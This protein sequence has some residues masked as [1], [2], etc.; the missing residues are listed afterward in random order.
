[1]HSLIRVRPWPFAICCWVLLLFSMYVPPTVFP[2]Y[3]SDATEG[4]AGLVAFYFY[5]SW[6]VFWSGLSATKTGRHVFA[7]AMLLIAAALVFAVC[8]GPI[9]QSN[10]PWWAYPWGILTG[11]A[12]FT[13]QVVA[14]STLRKAELARGTRIPAGGVSA[15]LWFFYFFIGWAPLHR[16]V[17]S[18]MGIDGE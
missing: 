4:L 1:M 13:P 17:R 12:L 18:A 7:S 10:P 11:F 8:S 2:S 3:I 16:R 5:P 14:A 15:F 6:V 9:P